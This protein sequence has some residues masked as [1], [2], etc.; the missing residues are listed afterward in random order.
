LEAKITQ[1]NL[2]KTIDAPLDNCHSGVAHRNNKHRNMRTKTILMAAV[3]VL[4]ASSAIAVTSVNVVGYVNVTL[5]QGYNLICNPLQQA[6]TS[7]NTVIPSA[8]AYAGVF[9]WDAATQTFMNST[10]FVPPSDG[11]PYWDIDYAIEPGEAF[12]I[13]SDPGTIT[14][15]GDVRQ[16]P[17]G[18]PALTTQ[19]TSPNFNFVG[20]QVPQQGALSAVLGYFPPVDSYAYI[21]KWDAASQTY[22][23]PFTYTA[24]SSG[25]PVGTWDPSDPVLGIAEGI[26]VFPGAP[27]TW[28]RDFQ[29]Q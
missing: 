27:G 4:G 25:T 26:L 16:N 15:V 3:G 5:Q 14:F 1:K 23:N 20:S 10:T 8:P 22:S 13:N 29:V 28:T 21:F 7:I 2:K 11:G 18:G 6:S 17:V 24:D 9:K 12:F 19:L